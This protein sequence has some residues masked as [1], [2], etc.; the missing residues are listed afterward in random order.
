[1]IKR[2]LIL[3]V[4]FTCLTKV[5]AVTEDSVAVRLCQEAEN[6][7]TGTNGAFLNKEK[8]LQLYIQAAER[9][10]I[11]AI[12]KVAGFYYQG[13]V[14]E[15]SMK[16][17]LS[18]LT[19]AAELGDA[20]AQNKV[21][22]CYYNGEGTI[23]NIE[24][25]EYWQLKAANQGNIHAMNNLRILYFNQ[26]KIEE[27]L[28]W[29]RMGAERGQIECQ[30]ELGGAY[31]NG[32]GVK[33]D[34]DQAAYWYKMAADNGHKSA[35]N[36]LAVI[37]HDEKDDYAQ[38]LYYLNKAAELGDENAFFNLG[39][40]Y[41]QGHGTEKDYTKAEEYY[42]KALKYD[43]SLTNSARYRLGVMYYEGRDGV[44]KDKKKGESLLKE[45]AKN[46]NEKAKKYLD[47]HK[48]KWTFTING[49]N[50]LHN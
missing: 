31:N 32:K 7:Y 3:A 49:E 20:V 12:H 45:A 46:G 2:I 14:V 26:D 30:Y 15:Q 4:M 9:N 43:N 29:T 34:K 44:K 17:Y 21:G 1:M 25:A 11:P 22:V 10:Y 8:A 23:Q 37:Y 33:E 24:K 39:F 50:V 38:A 42:K 5:I 41:E 18:W 16:D 19:K 40:T 48:V 13:E 27:S 6:A 47:E 35:C 28:K 36:I